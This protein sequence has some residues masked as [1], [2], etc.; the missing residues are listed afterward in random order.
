MNKVDQ[1]VE[2]THSS[3]LSAEVSFEA[4]YSFLA[5]GLGVLVVIYCG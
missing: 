1:I 3:F 4:G 2:T 5:D